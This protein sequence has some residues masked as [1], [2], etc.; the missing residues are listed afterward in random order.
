MGLARQFGP[1]IPFLRRYAR[2]LTGS[3]TAGDEFVRAALTELAE[4]P[5]QIN[6][7]LPSR[8]ALYQLFHKVAG[9]PTHDKASSDVKIHDLRLQSLAPVQRQ[10]FLL[11][12]TEGFSRADAAAVLGRSEDEIE[13]LV[14]EA[15]HEIENALTTRVLIIEDE[16]VI[17]A[18]L[19]S[20]VEDLGHEV[21]GNATTYREA[22]TLARQIPPGLILCDIQL[23]DN[24]SGIDAANDI[25]AEINVPVVFITAFPERLLT[26]KRPEPAYL[27]TKPF[28]ENMVKAT[29]GQAL[30]FHSRELA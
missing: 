15:L 25:L 22:I 23:A 28:Q 16:P 11:T 3:Q 14:C 17:A 9:S 12:A 26:G 29:I 6:H 1:H 24:S 5:S 30:F 4:S 8:I 21:T 19:E 2:A 7:D 27:I 18:D 20:L 13:S 10:A